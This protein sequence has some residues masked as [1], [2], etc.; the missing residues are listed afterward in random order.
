MV[1]TTPPHLYLLASLIALAVGPV[2]YTLAARGEWRLPDSLLAAAVAGLVLWEVLPEAVSDG[3]FWTIPFLGLGLVAPSLLERVSRPFA[4]GTHAISLM[5]ALLG[6]TLHA[7]LD[8]T[9]LTLTEGRASGLGGLPLAVIL[10]R[11]PVGLT[12]WLLMHSTGKVARAGVFAVIGAATVIGFTIGPEILL[13]L[14]LPAL[15]RFQALVAGSL[16]H[17]LFHRHP[18]GQGHAKA[19]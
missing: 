15:A 5:L 9:A 12:L 14:S 18:A 1:P 8:G 4:R 16:L 17:V 6:L 10:H 7:V 13:T 2:V 11:I 19:H 3:G